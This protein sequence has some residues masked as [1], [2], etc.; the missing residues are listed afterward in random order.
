MQLLEKHSECDFAVLDVTPGRDHTEP[1]AARLSQSGTPFVLLSGLRGTQ[2]PDALKAMP[3]LFK[4]IS[5]SA[6]VAAVRAT[7]SAESRR[8]N[9]FALQRSLGP[10]MTSPEP[11]RRQPR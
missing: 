8:W 7:I 2:L 5:W 3:L 4:P 10:K 6:L 9:P 11:W 1:I